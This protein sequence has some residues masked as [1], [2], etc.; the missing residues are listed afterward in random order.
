MRR[1]GAL[2]AGWA[3]VVAACGGSAETHPG[4][5]TGGGTDDAVAERTIGVYS[6]VVR[7]LV[8]KDHTFGAEESPFDRVFIVDGVSDEAG[9][10][11]RSSPRVILQP[12]SPDVRAGIAR[13]LVD[14]PPVE[15][16][17][18]PDS[19]VTG[20]KQCAHVKGNGV[21]ITLGPISD[22]EHSVTV[23]NS[24]FFACLGGQWLTY[25]L[26]R[27]DGDWRVVGTKGPIAIS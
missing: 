25:E 10:L 3:L 15:F 21:L 18:D 16:V 20:K 22:D 11:P 9:E 24:L 1:I 23:S 2:L 8:T 13:E 12:F 17:S 6:A 26:E 5:E 7:Q 27:A 19:V 14:L 4:S